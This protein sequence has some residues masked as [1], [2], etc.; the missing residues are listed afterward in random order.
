MKTK[1][2]YKVVTKE[3][4]SY[5]ISTTWDSCEFSVKY[6]EN[7]WVEPKNKHAPLMVFSDKRKAKSFLVNNRCGIGVVYECEYKPSKMKWGW[8][9]GSIWDQIKRKTSKKRLGVFGSVPEHTKFADA[10]KLTR[11][12]Y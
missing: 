12:I 6:K 10:V 4:E 3:L 11:K 5:I 2:G 8:C 7:E 1:I 9:L